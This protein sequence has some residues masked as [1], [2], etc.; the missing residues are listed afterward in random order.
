ME[1][2]EF[3]KYIMMCTIF[4]GKMNTMA[5]SIDLVI[6]VILENLRQDFKERDMLGRKIKLFKQNKD[7]ISPVYSGDFDELVKKIE[8]FNG[9]W[10]V[11]KH[12]MIVG[13]MNPYPTFE[14]DGAI[15]GFDPQTI[16]GIDSEFSEIMSSISIISN[17]LLPTPQST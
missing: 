17:K 15:Y 4:S 3:D 8:R 13:N 2:T 14:K 16:R 1:Q 6:K 12:G 9:N 5:N 11:T 10:N 7:K